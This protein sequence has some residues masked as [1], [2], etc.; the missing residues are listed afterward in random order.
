M[1]PTV[2]HYCLHLGLFA[3]NLTMSVQ[4]GLDQLRRYLRVLKFDGY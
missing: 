3:K 4:F 2:M 1:V